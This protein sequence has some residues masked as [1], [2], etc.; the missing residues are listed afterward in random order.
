MFCNSAF[1]LKTQEIDMSNEIKILN[2]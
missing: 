1:Q 2:F